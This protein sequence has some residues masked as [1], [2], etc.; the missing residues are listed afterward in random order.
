V[1]TSPEDAVRRYLAWVEDPDSA[2]DPDAVLAADEAF[3]KAEDPIA[4]LHA[5]AARERA[6]TADASAIERDF[7]AH[8]KS[9]A[10]AHDIPASAF[11][12]LGVGPDVLT[13]AGFAAGT[14]GRKPSRPAVRRAA[15]PVTR[16]AQVSVSQIKAAASTMSEPFTLAQLA[17]AAGG[18]SPATI[19]KAVE[20]LIAQG[21]VIKLG[22]A[23]DHVG[24]GRAP[25][26]Y[27]LA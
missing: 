1:T 12:A 9:Y 21:K 22:P 24:P 15:G 19:R 26:V 2:V 16:A 25:V 10:E 8:A 23:S 13:R 14:R 11:A 5:A 27:A 20:D 17:V 3:R 7:I 18:G 6:A 4:K